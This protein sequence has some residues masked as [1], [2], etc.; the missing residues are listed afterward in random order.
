M[1]IWRDIKFSIEI[2]YLSKINQTHIA[3]V[4]ELLILQLTLISFMPVWKHI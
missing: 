1:A 4:Y 2:A 3:C